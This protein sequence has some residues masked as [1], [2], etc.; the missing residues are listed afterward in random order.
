MKKKIIQIKISLFIYLF[1][2]LK[3]NIVYWSI[4]SKRKSNFF[5]GALEEL[6]FVVWE[7][8]DN[9]VVAFTVVFV[10]VDS[11]WVVDNNFVEVLVVLVVVDSSEDIV[12]CAES[13]QVS[14]DWFVSSIV[15]W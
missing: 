1:I 6:E 9:E 15:E 12:S 11:L 5:F 4:E 10:V 14:V 3:K 7:T 2:W 13:D 8:C